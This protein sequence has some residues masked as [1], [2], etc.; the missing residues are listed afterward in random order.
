MKTEQI[1]VVFGLA[2]LVFGLA[3]VRRAQAATTAFSETMATSTARPW[4]GTGCDN[5]WTV[6]CS[7]GTPFQ[8]STNW[9]YGGGN[10]CGMQ[11]KGG[12]AGLTNNMVTATS[13]ITATGTSGYAEF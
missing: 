3:A 12:V 10:P 13:G 4:T 1:P 7:S 6:F 11:F 5:A 9:N 2:L 8:Q